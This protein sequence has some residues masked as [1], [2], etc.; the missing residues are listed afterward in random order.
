MRLYSAEEEER[1]RVQRQ[2]RDWTSEGLLDG[3]QSARLL[4]DLRVDL[5]RTNPFLR[6]GLALFTLLIAGAVVGLMATSLDLQASSAFAILAAIAAAGYLASAEY[7]VRHY[8]LYRHGA[9]EALAVAAVVLLAVSAL[10]I[11]QSVPLYSIPWLV[12]AAG[13]LGLYCRYGFVYAAIAGLTCAAAIPFQF[14]FQLPPAAQRFLA[15]AIVAA[16]GLVLRAKR[17]EH[18]DDFPGDE[19]G[20][21]QA[22]ALAGVYLALNVQLTPYAY[23][24]SGWFYWL[25]YVAIWIVPAAGLYAGGRDKDRPLVD[26]SLALLIVTLV[27]NKPY[28][29]WERR[30]WDPCLLGIVAVAAAIAIRRWLSS[31]PGG[32]RHGFTAE[33]RDRDRSPL[34]ALGRLSVALPSGAPASSAA[35]TPA[36]FGGGRSGGAGGGAEF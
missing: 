3:A 8:R 26:V 1:I 21:L 22:A 4:A 6:G 15:A 2:V 18:G 12:A 5:R 11:T 16:A 30:T 36:G 34:S 25:T 20:Y 27:T 29:G 35:S 9:E 24:V 31:G 10:E 23:A 33:A 19:Y 7:L 14:E 32:V 17:L 28:L 13:G